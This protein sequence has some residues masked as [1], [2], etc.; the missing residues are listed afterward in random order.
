MN[1]TSHE[2]D[3]LNQASEVGARSAL[4]CYVLTLN[5][6]RYLA[7]VLEPIRPV[8]DDLLVVDSGSTDS[9]LSV[10]AAF[11]ARVIHHPF[12][13]FREQRNFAQDQCRHRWVLA[14]DADEVPTMSFVA[15]LRWLKEQGFHQNGSEPD[16]FQIERAW[17]VKG[18][19]VHAFFPVK[20]PDF[21]IRLVRRDR[22]R[23][24]RDACAVHAG[25]SG[26]RA[27]GRLEGV[28]NHFTCERDD[29]L[30]AKL[31]FYTTMAAQDMRR[32]GRSSTWAARAFAP[33]GAWLKWHLRKGGWRDGDVGRLLSSYAFLYTR[34]KYQKLQQL[35]RGSEV[36]SPAGRRSRTASETR[37]SAL[38]E[39]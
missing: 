29:E 4:S 12:S 1:H 6:E 17:F 20:S 18:Q 2:I 23:Y 39:E 27:L 21:P 13:N 11:G 33:V 32:R 8:C 37:S 30:F 10:C 34:Q 3:A 19:P 31:D 7:R 24:D 15:A 25:P 38:T 35:Q 22:V 5:A 28:V 26:H 9:T 36:P 14:L 16:A